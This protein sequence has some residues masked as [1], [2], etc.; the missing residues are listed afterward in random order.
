M[1]VAVCV[2]NTDEAGSQDLNAEP[3]TA[4]LVARV[5]GQPT[6]DA[7]DSEKARQIYEQYM[8]Q[9]SAIKT[10]PSPYHTRIMAKISSFIWR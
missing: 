4:P 2:L 3:E 6:E 7:G 1:S 8:S 10:G 5:E 9:T